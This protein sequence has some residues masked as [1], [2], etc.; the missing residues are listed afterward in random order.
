[1]EHTLELKGFWWLPGSARNKLP[2]TLTYSQADGAI[3]EIVG[4]FKRERFSQIEH[5]TIILGISQQGSPITLYKCLTTKLNDPLTGLGSGESRYHARYMFE[6]VHFPSEE[7]IKFHEVQASFTDLDSWIDVYGF[8][9]ERDKIGEKYISKVSY[10]LP[11]TRLFNVDNVFNVGVGFSSSGP[12]ASV[13][14]TEIKITQRAYLLVKSKKGDINFD[15]LFQQF[16]RFSYLLQFGVQRIPYPLAV[17]GYSKRRSEKLDSKK[18][19][20]PPISI[21]YSPIEPITNQKD[22]S[23]FEMLFTFTDLTE[24]QIANW[25]L[26]F[27]KYQGIINLYRTLFYSNR[28]F[29]ETRFLNIAQA[30]ESLHS[31]QFGSQDL[32]PDIFSERK[33]R[34]LRGVPSDLAEWVKSALNNA[35][36]KSFRFRILDLLTHKKKFMDLLVDDLDLFAKRVRDTRNEYVHNTKQKLTFERGEELR[37]AITVLTVLFETHL[38][39]IIGFSDEKILEL[40]EPKIKSHQTGWKHVRG[41]RS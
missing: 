33:K 24:E 11:E 27:D 31:I 3:L 25:F 5:P 8:K 29:M 20:Y 14:Q 13:V 1:M 26:G 16:H 34:V 4:V 21:Y 19:F 18:T 9:I 15:D 36:F 39:E 22:R 12:N 41:K 37:S 35:N 10:E 2:G 32:P 38:L 17:V 23:P 30:L 40:I 7:K 6:G 28:L